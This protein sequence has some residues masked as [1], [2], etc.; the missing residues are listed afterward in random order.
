MSNP[1]RSEPDYD[2][3]FVMLALTTAG[4]FA[5]VDEADYTLASQRTWC[6]MRNNNC[7]HVGRSTWAPELGRCRT[8]YLHTLLTGYAKTDHVN[9]NGLDNRRIN[10]REATHAQNSA[11][12][13]PNR[14]S[15]TGLKGVF[16]RGVSYRAQIKVDGNLIRLGR[17]KDPIAAARAYNAAALEHFGEFAWLNP[18]P[19]SRPRVPKLRWLSRWHPIRPGRPARCPAITRRDTGASPGITGSGSR[20]SGSTDGWRSSA[21]L[22]IRSKPPERITGQPLRRSG[23]SRG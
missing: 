17:F 16:Q 18:V 4:K 2:G 1:A 8:E 23:S 22:T 10:L 14:N 19:P 20:A 9:G 12:R 13:G 7:W 11:N 5:L 3:H 21:C 15:T 6:A